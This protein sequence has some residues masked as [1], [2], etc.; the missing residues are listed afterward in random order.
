MIS[1]MARARA[2]LVILAVIA[3]AWFAIGARQ[4][5][6]LNAATHILSRSAPLRPAQDRQVAALLNSAATLNPDHQVDVLR[7]QLATA[8]GQ[9]ARARQILLGVIH[10]EPKNLQ[11]WIAYATAAR[12]DPAAFNAAV[13]AVRRLIPIVK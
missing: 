1:R 8:E 6:D 2:L 9:Y 7:G 11:A 5:H 3:C 13:I 12:N 10:G 4:A